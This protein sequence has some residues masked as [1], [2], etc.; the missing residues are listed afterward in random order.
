MALWQEEECEI[1]EVCGS[2]V[3]MSLGAWS[4][5]RL[6]VGAILKD[7]GLREARRELV[8]EKERV[9]SS[10]EKESEKKDLGSAGS[11]DTGCWCEGLVAPRCL[12]AS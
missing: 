5:P 10:P 2:L 7:S 8:A 3:S 1:W 4:E 12:F 9:E 6:E 11:S